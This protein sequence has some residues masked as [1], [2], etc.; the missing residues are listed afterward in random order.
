MLIYH[1]LIFRQD[2]CYSCLV[3]YDRHYNVLQV[4]EGRGCLIIVSMKTAICFRKI[5]TLE[6]LIIIYFAMSVF[7]I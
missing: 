1:F 2:A 3:F 5:N 7:H 6:R 4:Q